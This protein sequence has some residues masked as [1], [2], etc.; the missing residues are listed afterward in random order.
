ME[1]DK[2]KGEGGKTSGSATGVDHSLKRMEGFLS[3]IVMHLKSGIDMPIDQAR[4]MDLMPS[5]YCEV[6]YSKT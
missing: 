1:L 5:I 4:N 6:G 3:K 2:L